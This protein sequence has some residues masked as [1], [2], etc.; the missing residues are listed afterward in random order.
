[1]RQANTPPPK[2]N[3]HILSLSSPLSRPMRK[4]Q[5]SISSHRTT[6]CSAS[7]RMSKDC[8]RGLTKSCPLATWAAL[9][10]LGYLPPAAPG[11]AGAHAHC[12]TY[13]QCAE[14]QGSFFITAACEISLLSKHSI[15]ANISSNTTTPSSHS[16]P[17]QAG[18]SCTSAANTDLAQVLGAICF[19]SLW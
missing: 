13:Q 3:N 17:M 15:R 12:D 10:H 9:L 1:M 2:I 7:P 6:S 19:T 5:N 4:C 11:P 14:L 18:A 8:P 16:P